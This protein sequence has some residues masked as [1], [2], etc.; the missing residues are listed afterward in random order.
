MFVGEYAFTGKHADMVRSL[1]SKIDN[2]SNTKIFE[3]AIELYIAA[4]IIGVHYNVQAERQKSDNTFKI[5]ADQFKNHYSECLYVF[6]LVMLNANNRAEAEIDR[7]NNAF[8]FSEEDEE[9]AANYKEFERYVL[10][11]IEKLYKSFFESNNKRYEDY[12]ESLERLLSE[13]T[14]INETSYLNSNEEE[15]SFDPVF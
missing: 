4:A 11:G 3:S 6:K 1:T 5:F 8:K 7:I 9:Y 10:G 13:L 15:I 2:A 14:S 12:L